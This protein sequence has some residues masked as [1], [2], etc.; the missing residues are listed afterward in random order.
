MLSEVF[1]GFIWLGIIITDVDIAW[2]AASSNTVDYRT[3]VRFVN[4]PYF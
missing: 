3:G 1:N 4:N 2:S